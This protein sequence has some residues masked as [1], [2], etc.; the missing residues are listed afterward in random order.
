[1]PEIEL[2]PFYFLATIYHN[3]WPVFSCRFKQRPKIHL[4]HGSHQSSWFPFV[5]WKLTLSKPT[6][7][8]KQILTSPNPSHPSNLLLAL[9]PSSYCVSN[10]TEPH[11]SWNHLDRTSLSYKLKGQN[12][13]DLHPT[14][15]E[16]IHHYSYEIREPSQLNWRGICLCCHSYHVSGR[17]QYTMASAWLGLRKLNFAPSIF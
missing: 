4:T 9:L 5:L 17:K 11:H 12:H 1:M 14:A 7:W 8:G 3:N 16:L 15:L 2:V 6:F 10:P 13:L